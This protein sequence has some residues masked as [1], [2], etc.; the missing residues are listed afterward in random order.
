[1]VAD[2]KQTNGQ[3]NKQTAPLYSIF[4]S[5]LSNIYNTLLSI[6]V[7]V[8]S[9]SREVEIKK[10][11]HTGK[12]TLSEWMNE[13]EKRKK[14]SN[15]LKTISFWMNIRNN[16]IICT[17]F[18]QEKLCIPQTHKAYRPSS[19]WRLSLRWSAQVNQG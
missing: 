18:S 9:T 15:N 14:Y 19:K 1:M 3:S 13:W 8:Q 11:A 16:I 5:L 6:S 12:K 4:N 17:S 7:N 2:E 10:K